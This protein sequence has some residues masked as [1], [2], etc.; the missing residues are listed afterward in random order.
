MQN[1][2][3]QVTSAATKGCLGLHLRPNSMGC[4]Q[5][6]RYDQGSDSYLHVQRGPDDQLPH[7]LPQHDEKVVHGPVV[8]DAW[9]CC[10]KRP[11]DHECFDEQPREIAVLEVAFDACQLCP[12]G[13][14]C[15]H[16]PAGRSVCEPQVMVPCMR[17]SNSC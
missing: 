1:N 13:T 14:A 17:S 9:G 10:V 2:A 3:Q 5:Q 8:W 16:N 15:C 7:H 4:L 12:I 6:A 11:L